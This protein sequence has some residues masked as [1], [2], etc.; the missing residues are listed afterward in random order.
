VHQYLAL[1]I[2]EQRETA[3]YRTANASRVEAINKQ[4]HPAE[5]ERARLE[6]QAGLDK[7]AETY[8]TQRHKLVDGF[9]AATE[10]LGTIS[11]VTG[12]DLGKLQ[13]G[14]KDEIQLMLAACPNWTKEYWQEKLI[15]LACK[16]DTPALNAL[17][18]VCKSYAARKSYMKKEV[19]GQHVPD[20]DLLEDLKLATEA[21]V[22]P[23]MR[24]HKFAMRLS[25]DLR[26]AFAACVNIADNTGDPVTFSQIAAGPLETFR[27][28]SAG[29]AIAGDAADFNARFI[30]NVEAIASGDKAVV[31]E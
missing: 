23:A 10:R 30:E 12:A 19:G 7:I 24:K 14:Q 4:T 21:G 20:M 28:P 27:A 9:V 29:D 8:D 17:I 1:G 3:K 18:P 25:D 11:D 2:T 26:S 5:Y 6:Y 31:I 16:R 13:D 15:D 22:S